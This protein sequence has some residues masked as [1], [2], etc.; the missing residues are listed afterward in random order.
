MTLYDQIIDEAEQLAF[1]NNTLKD[2]EVVDSLSQIV[3]IH[4]NPNS[5]GAKLAVASY[6]R[7]A[8]VTQQIG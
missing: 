6:K 7:V 5:T 4:L 1:V 8:G 2:N 3:N